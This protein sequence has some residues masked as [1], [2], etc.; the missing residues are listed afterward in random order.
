MAAS[1]AESPD[2]A[3]KLG[4]EPG[5]VDGSIARS[6][7]RA[8]DSASGRAVEGV[9]GLSIRNAADIGISP[10]AADGGMLAAHRPRSRIGR[11][12]RPPIAT[13]LAESTDCIAAL[14]VSPGGHRG[15][16]G[17]VKD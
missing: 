9:I 4:I 6:T 8:A 17:W 14:G 15:R 11:P 1:L 12:L 3:R 7:F 2:C 10:W 13:S 16:H 5:A